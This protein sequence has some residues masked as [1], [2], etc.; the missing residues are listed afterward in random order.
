VQTKQKSA[1]S[2]LA[3]TIR[4][5]GTAASDHVRSI[6]DFVLIALELYKRLKRM[7]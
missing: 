4:P 1:Q 5:E 3:A 2:A 7:S 6:A